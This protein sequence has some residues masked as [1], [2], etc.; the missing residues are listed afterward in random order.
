M[1]G[2][3]LMFFSLCRPFLRPRDRNDGREVGKEKICLRHE[4]SLSTYELAEESDGTQRL[5]DFI[6][7]L[8]T[9]D[10]GAYIELVR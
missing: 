6:D 3:E 5:F 9:N 4:G 2:A 10:R 8:L 1:T 7:L